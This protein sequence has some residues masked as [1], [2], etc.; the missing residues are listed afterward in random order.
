MGSREFRW[1]I[2]A[3]RRVVLFRVEHLLP[4]RAD[5]PLNSRQNGKDAPESSSQVTGYSTT[6]SSVVLVFLAW[7]EECRGS[8]PFRGHWGPERAD[9]FATYRHYPE[10]SPW[11]IYEI[12]NG[13]ERSNDDSVEVHRASIVWRKVG[14]E[15]LCQT[16]FFLIP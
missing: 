5:F 4:K 2:G 7:A 15:W 11:Q 3:K 12:P 14:D 10:I 6:Q 13:V 8:G 16:D 1:C 9:V